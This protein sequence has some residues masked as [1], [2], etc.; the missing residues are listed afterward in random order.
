MKTNENSGPTK[1]RSVRMLAK[2]GKVALRARKGNSGIESLFLD[3]KIEEKRY[4]LFIELYLTPVKT[5]LDRETN[6]ETIRIAE[7]LRAK[8]ELELNAGDNDMIPQHRRKVDFIEYFKT[9]IQNYMNKDKRLV[10]ASS[11]HFFKFVGK[12]V[13]PSNE[14]NENMVQQF[15][16]YLG[17]NLNGETPANYFKK[18]KKVVKCA[19]NDNI[20]KKDPTLGISIKAIEGVKKEILLMSEIQKMAQTKCGNDAV[21]TAFLFSRLSEF[22][23]RLRREEYSQNISSI[24][25]LHSTCW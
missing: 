25:A 24:T 17:N 21:K 8:K 13:L 4:R 7:S 14:L 20:F 18:F 5:A 16:T 9:F 6:K 11:K 22:N 3:Y 1:N 10:E 2:G 15:K 12:E 19:V 23:E